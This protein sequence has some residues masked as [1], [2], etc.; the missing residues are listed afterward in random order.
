MFDFLLELGAFTYIL[1][2]IGSFPVM[3]FNGNSLKFE[4]LKGIF[5]EDRGDASKV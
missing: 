3:L 1:F 5:K 2:L 4:I